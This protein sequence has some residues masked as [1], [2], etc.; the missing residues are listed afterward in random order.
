MSDQKNVF[1][2]TDV[3]T[4]SYPEYVSVNERE[5]K[6]MVT[7]RGPAVKHGEIVWPGHAT[8]MRLP[9]GQ[10]AAMGRALLEYA[11]S[12]SGWP[13]EL[14]NLLP[15]ADGGVTIREDEEPSSDEGC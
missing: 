1:A 15:T 4:A 3:S 12:D 9:R 14:G 8:E 13:K 10:A 5:G 11:Q 6:L 7:V 2:Y